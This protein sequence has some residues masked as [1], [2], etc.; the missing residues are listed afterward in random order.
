MN[1]KDAVHWWIDS[2]GSVFLENER[3]Q[4]FLYEK[5]ERERFRFVEGAIPE[6]REDGR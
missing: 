6:L 4:V 5:L 3:G 2:D 1:P